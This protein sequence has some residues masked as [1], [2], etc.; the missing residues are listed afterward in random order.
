MREHKKKADP[1][2]GSGPAAARARQ[3]KEGLPLS[4]RGLNDRSDST[5]LAEVLA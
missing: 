5:E 1:G 4:G 3:Y 2:F